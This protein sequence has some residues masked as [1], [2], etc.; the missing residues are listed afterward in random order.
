[1][2]E[3]SCP[4]VRVGREKCLSEKPSYGEKLVTDST[5]PPHGVNPCGHIE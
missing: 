3:K 4:R 1:M 2:G 5:M